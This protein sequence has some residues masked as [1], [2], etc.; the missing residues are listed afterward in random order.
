MEFDK[1]TNHIAQLSNKK[2]QLVG[3]TLPH[4]STFIIISSEFTLDNKCLDKPYGCCNVNYVI[5]ISV[6]QDDFG[7]TLDFSINQKRVS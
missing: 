6:K 3:P 4:I 1:L 7:L 5:Y 2:G